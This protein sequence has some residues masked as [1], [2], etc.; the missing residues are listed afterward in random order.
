MHFKVVNTEKVVGTRPV[1]VLEG[2]N[3]QLDLAHVKPKD[4]NEHTRR[5]QHNVSL[6]HLKY[7]RKKHELVDVSQV[8][9]FV[10]GPYISSLDQCIHP[11]FV[12]LPDV[13]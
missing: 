9:P 3:Q 12:E 2:P 10:H 1:E 4:A 11:V 8:K 7:L 5:Q 13:G 6:R